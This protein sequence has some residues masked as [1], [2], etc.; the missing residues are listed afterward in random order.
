[1]FS[2][3][4]AVTRRSRGEP[5]RARDFS[6]GMR[7]QTRKPRGIITPASSVHNAYPQRVCLSFMFEWRDAPTLP[8]ELSE[9]SVIFKAET[10]GAIFAERV[11]RPPLICRVAFEHPR[12]VY[13]RGTSPYDRPIGGR[14]AR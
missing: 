1:M 13:H 14:R 12:E 7:K 4:C 10:R 5:L 11:Y 8:V 6:A 9:K 2:P 3:A